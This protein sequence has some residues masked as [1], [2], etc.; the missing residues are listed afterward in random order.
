MALCCY[1]LIRSD[2]ELQSVQTSEAF[3]CEFTVTGVA[4]FFHSNIQNGAFDPCDVLNILN[5]CDCL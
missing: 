3:S 4:K 5:E 2:E 1:S